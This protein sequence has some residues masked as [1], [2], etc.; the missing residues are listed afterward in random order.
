GKYQVLP[1]DGRGQQRF[2]DERPQLAR[3]RSRYVYYPHLESVPENVAAKVLNR[4]HSITARATIPPGGAEGV[5][6][7]HGGNTGGYAFFVRDGHLHH[8]HNYVGARWLRVRSDGP[9]P[10]GEVELRFT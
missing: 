10:V 1:I 8:V 2:A 4:A 5:I 7:C 9:L 6:L 3:E